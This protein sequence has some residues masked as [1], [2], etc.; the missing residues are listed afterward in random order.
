MIWWFDSSLLSLLHHKQPQHTTTTTTRNGNSNSTQR[1]KRTHAHAHAH[2]PVHVNACEYVHV[3]VCEN[4]RVCAQAN[5][6]TTSLTHINVKNIRQSAIGKI[7]SP[8]SLRKYHLFRI[9]FVRIDFR[10]VHRFQLLK[11][12]NQHVTLPNSP[13]HNAM[14]PKKT[15]QVKLSFHFNGSFIVLHS[16]RVVL[17]Q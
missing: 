3:R 6:Y 4:V 15:T 9:E 13:A 10:C 5:V 8:F 14:N 12:C 2:V 1:Q 17:N 16:Y 11:V 7:N